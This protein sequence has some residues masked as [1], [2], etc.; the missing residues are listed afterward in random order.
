MGSFFDIL[1]TAYSQGLKKKYT[2][3]KIYHG[4]ED[5]DLTKC[6]YVYFLF[7]HPTKCDKHDNPVLLHKTILEL[8]KVIE[9]LPRYGHFI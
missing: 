3:P 6:W 1:Q 5:Y 2:E 7:Q 8:I 4:G 9:F